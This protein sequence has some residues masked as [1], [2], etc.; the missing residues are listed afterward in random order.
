MTSPTGCMMTRNK[1]KKQLTSKLIIIIYWTNIVYIFFY[2]YS[3]LTFHKCLFLKGID[4][5]ELV[6]TT[7][8]EDKC[9][10]IDNIRSKSK[11]GIKIFIYI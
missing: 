6:E 1:L 4:N 11:K 3:N 7:V 8:I 9:L 5:S 2:I 10:K